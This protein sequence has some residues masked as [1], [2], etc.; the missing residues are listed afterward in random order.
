MTATDESYEG[1]AIVARNYDLG[2][3]GEDAVQKRCTENIARSATCQ[4]IIKVQQSKFS[5]SADPYLQ[6]DCELCYD[7]GSTATTVNTV[8]V[9]RLNPSYHTEAAASRQRASPCL[10]YVLACPRA[11]GVE[12]LAIC[13]ERYGVSPRE[14]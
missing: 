7:S 12:N 1:M 2:G 14:K 13:V 10:S 9:H 6:R 3:L 4:A 11:N 5:F 8:Y